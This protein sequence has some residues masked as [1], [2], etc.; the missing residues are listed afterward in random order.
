MLKTLMKAFLADF[1][2]LYYR[3]GHSQGFNLTLASETVWRLAK[4][5]PRTL[6]EL[7]VCYRKPATLFRRRSLIIRSAAT[8]FVYPLSQTHIYVKSSTHQYIISLKNRH[9][10]PTAVCPHI[11]IQWLPQK[12]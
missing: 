4:G 9:Q 12:S 10:Y 1:W 5:R 6:V 8:L 3:G 7:G 11:G 2:Y